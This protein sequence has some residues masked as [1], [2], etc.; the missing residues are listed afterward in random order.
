M[1]KTGI[2][3][4]M[5]LENISIPPASACSKVIKRMSSLHAGSLFLFFLALV[6]QDAV[7]STILDNLDPQSYRDEAA[8]YQMVGKVNGSGFNGSGVLISDRWVLTA[9]HVADFKT[10]GT[11]SVGG[12]SRTIQSVISHPQHSA[13]ST[14]Y[15]VGLLELASPIVEIASATMLRLMDPMS[16]LGREAVWVGHGLTGTGLTGAQSTFEFR[17]FTNII[18]GFTPAFGL[19]GPSFYSDFD[20][21]DGSGNS[22]T[23]SSPVPTRLEGNV[24]SGDSGGGVFL[25]VDGQRYLVGINSYTSGFSPG[26]NSKYGSLSGAADL[27]QFH[28]WIFEKTGIAAIPEPSSIWFGTLAAFMLLRRSRRAGRSPH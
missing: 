5:I 16:L 21:A 15:D 27:H 20:N 7:A 1:G 6:F 4:R 23:S 3:A 24:T 28:A 19:P 12:V 11:F 25:T 2:N 9:G 18:E 14:T 22:L 26:L 8:F 10:G 17:A 13:L